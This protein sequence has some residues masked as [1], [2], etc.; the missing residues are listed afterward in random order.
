MLDMSIIA[1]MAL[2]MRVAIKG[3]GM[4]HI[5]QANRSVTYAGKNSASTL[6]SIDQAVM[7]RSTKRVMRK[8]IFTD[9]RKI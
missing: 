8:Q 3:E 5:F 2:K 1:T 6:I 4:H 9:S 7:R